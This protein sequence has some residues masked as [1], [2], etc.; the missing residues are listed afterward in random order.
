MGISIFGLWRSAGKR[1]TRKSA[2][3]SRAIS[4]R[5]LRIEP[6]EARSLLSAAPALPANWQAEP[7]HKLVGP[8]VHA[9]SSSTSGLT[10]AQVRAAYGLSNG[11]S[12]GLSYAISFNGSSGD[13]SGQTIAIVDAYDDPNA[14]SDLNT[15]SSTYGLPQFNG[16][17]QPTF[18]KMDE[19]GGTNYPG[20]DPAGKLNGSNNDWEL[21]ESLDI[22]W[23]HAMAPMAN[24]IL[25]EASSAGNDLY[26]AVQTAASIPGVV[27]VSMSWSGGE[28][29]GESSFDS[30]YFVTPAN[31]LGGAATMGG[32]QVKGGVTFLAATGDN[33]AYANGTTTITPQYPATSPNVI[34]VGGTNLTVNQSSSTGNYY[35]NGETSW[36]NGTSSGSSGGGGGGVS[37][38]ET[39]QP[40][41]QGTIVSSTGQSIVSAT[42]SKDNGRYTATHRTYP[43]VSADANSSVLVYDSYSTVGNSWGVIGTSLACPLWAGMI[44]VA[45]QGRAISGVGSLNGASQ[46]LPLLYAL[47]AGTSPST[48]FNDI[49]SGNS[50]GTD[51]NSLTYSPAAGYDLA[52]GL[53]S[54]K[55]A[56]LIPALVGAFNLTFVQQPSTTV[57]G[58][59][60]SPAITVDVEDSSG[61]VVTTDNSNVTLTIGNNP[62]SGTLSGTVTVAAVHGVA[63]FSNLSI[64]NAGA[65][66]TLVASDTLGTNTLT[67]TSAAFNIGTPPTVATPAS[68][69]PNPVAAATTNLSVLGADVNGE[70]T[71]TYTWTATSLP[72]GA[73][74]P[75]FSANGTNAA[76]NTTATFSA[77]GTYVLTANIVDPANGGAASSVSVTVSQTATSLTVA[78]ALVGVAAGAT[79]QFTATVLDQFGAAL[80]S[81]PS[82]TWSTTTGSIASGGLFTSAGTA[83]T[84]TATDG[85]ISGNAQILTYQPPTVVNA[86]AASSGTVTGTTTN[87]SVLGDD[88]GGESSLT[89]TWTATTLPSGAAQPTY[90]VNGANAAKN[91]TATF[92]SAGTYVLQ[93]TITDANNWTVASSVTVVVNSTLTSLGISPSTITVS[94]DTQSQLTSLFSVSGLDQF[95]N[96]VNNPASLAWSATGGAVSSTAWYTPPAASSSDTITVTSGGLHNSAT[97]NIAAPVGWWKFN[98]GSGT[99][100]KDSGAGTADNGTIGSSGDWLSPANGTYGTP[101]LQ[102]NG[103][104]GTLVSLGNPSKLAFTGQITL[105]AWIKPTSITTAQYIIDHRTGT[106]NDVF[107]M[108]TSTGLYEVGVNN[109]SFH[110]ATYAIPSS[111]MGAWVHLAG[112][113]DGTTW[114]LY[115]NGILVASSVSST[116]A[117]S[118]NGNWGIGGALSGSQSK[119]YFTGAIDDVRIY[120]TAIS[121]SAVG[122]LMVQPPTIA[123]A[124]AP[125]SNPVTGTTAALSALGADD[126]GPASLTYTW[127]ATGS[128]PAAVSFSS[129]GTNAAQNTTATFTQAGAYNIAAT[130]TNLGNLTATSF[131]TVT[132]DQT[133]T[134][135]AVQAGPPALDGAMTFS[136]TANDQFGN[137]MTAQPQ[138]AWSVVDGGAISTG[139]VFTPPYASGSATITAASG[140]A[141]GNDTVSLPGAAQWN[142]SGNTSWNAAGTWTSSS[143]GVAISAPGTRSIAGDNAVF[144]NTTGGTVT[145]DGASPSLA[146]LT[147]GDAGSYTIAEGSG[148]AL[149]L[150]NGSAGAAVTVAA[151][152]QTISA[153]LVLESNVTISAAA[154][155]LLTVSGPITVNGHT[156]TVI[157]PGKVVFTGPGGSGLDST[158]VASGKLVIQDPSMLADGSS[159]T[160][161]NASFFAAA[162]AVGVPALA[163]ASVAKSTPTSAATTSKAAAVAAAPPKVTTYQGGPA[164]PLWL[165]PHLQAATAVLAGQGASLSNRDIPAAIQAVDAFFASFGR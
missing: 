69:T 39:P 134:S 54:P 91:T 162:P 158:T 58:A 148:G 130:V 67:A 117:I 113:Y 99:T 56:A 77:A 61:N 70:P 161:G 47:A 14:L 149:H 132:V 120:N 138:F 124:A 19:N 13:G 66:Y 28:I 48:Y 109:G 131:V 137:A 10:P 1:Q 44:A 147:F 35:Y 79:Q 45:D 85:S 126:A 59:T 71:L 72:A 15:F 18:Q 68:A 21:E 118:P 32:A 36:G 133:L 144:A 22:E 153:P 41:Y 33:G 129:N 31:H 157:G 76:K 29:S 50:I 110:G 164:L 8:I 95:G 87:L 52:T 101:A 92:S 30:T 37:T 143:T 12:S 53:G 42:F 5:V 34:A 115:L 78:P 26:T 139:G 60:I 135:I 123:T 74:A 112:T 38:Q 11:S 3:P 98:E 104:S 83:G 20:V 27:A 107:L 4:S 103:T 24:I 64:N 88:A 86:A 151:G 121:S 159:L 97:V 17:G 55:A 165:R 23:A 160:V 49:T 102:F 73:T 136:A 51:G 62:G 114:R 9:D 93:A 108:I 156:I 94:A 96:S 127:A 154:G 40:G 84:V 57:D 141:S 155:T 2:R 145:L 150:A 63:T 6:L 75:T 119:R 16:T 105:S 152:A 46:A 80:A 122:G 81:Q 89:Y 128:P 82:V 65:G 43:D 146:G 90:T 163:G 116:G 106:T 100:V 7:A 25:V 125:V 142:S 111:D 140:A